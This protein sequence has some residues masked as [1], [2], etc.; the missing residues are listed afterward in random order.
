MMTT[1]ANRIWIRLLTSVMSLGTDLE[2]RGMHCREIIHHTTVLPMAESVVTVRER[3]LSYKHLVNEALWILEG[4]QDLDTI[5]RFAPSYEKYSD[6]G[7]TLFGAYGPKIVGQV[8]YVVKTLANDLYTRQAVIN[9]WKEKPG[10]SKDIPCTLSLQFLIRQNCV[11]CCATMRSSDCWLGWP[12]DV[13]VFSMVSAM[14][15]TRLRQVTSHQ[16]ELGQLFLNVGSQH[17]YYKDMEKVNTLLKTTKDNWAIRP[18]SIWSLNSPVHLKDSLCDMLEKRFVDGE[19]LG[20]NDL[21]KLVN[22]VVNV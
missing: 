11:H 19:C 6:D 20:F 14:V 15:A 8:E 22:M 4:R 13:F 1:Q 12:H 17:I 21:N 16:F 3:K 7:V 9:I 10:I 5:K 18:I 2:I